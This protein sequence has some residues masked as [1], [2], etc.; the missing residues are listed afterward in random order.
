MN[1]RAVDVDQ[2]EHLLSLTGKI[3]C[4]PSLALCKLEIEPHTSDPRTGEPDVGRPE[5]QVHNK[6]DVSLGFMRTTLGGRQEG[7]NERKAW[8]F[9]LIAT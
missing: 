5:N 8:I 2:L 9:R 4:V 7:K 6:F 3:L 1:S